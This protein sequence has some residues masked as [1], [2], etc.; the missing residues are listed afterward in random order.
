M[1]RLEIQAGPGTYALFLVCASVCRIQV[2]RLGRLRTKPGYY[3]YIGSAFGPG[4]I[5][6]RI[7]HHIR[8]ANRCHWHIDY[9][10]Q[11]TQPVSCWYTHDPIRREHEWAGLVAALPQAE[12]PL[13]GFGSSDCRCRSHLIWLPSL[14]PCRSFRDTLGTGLPDHDTILETSLT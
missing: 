4:G 6:A 1:A 10:R 12:I 13:V 3:A 7:A 14:P 11:I 8:S 2:G 5:Y 9:L